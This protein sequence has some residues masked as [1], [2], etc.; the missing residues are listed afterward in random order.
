MP[1]RLMPWRQ[2]DPG[3]GFSIGL[4]RAEPPAS[5]HGLGGPP[6]HG[7]AGPFKQR[8]GLRAP[9]LA[10]TLCSLQADSLFGTGDVGAGMC[11]SKP[12]RAGAGRVIVVDSARQR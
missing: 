8:R 3:R 11:R 6:R 9:R 5:G 10:A 12:P 1:N 4:D 2:A 7:S